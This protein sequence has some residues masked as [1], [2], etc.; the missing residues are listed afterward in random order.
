[1]K[2]MTPSNVYLQIPMIFVTKDSQY[3][4][5][6]L[7]RHSSLGSVSKGSMNI[8]ADAFDVCHR[9]YIFNEKAISGAKKLYYWWSLESH[10]NFGFN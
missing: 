6:P 3:Y 7:S 8:N 4:A 2:W 1:M 9:H 5:S 10:A